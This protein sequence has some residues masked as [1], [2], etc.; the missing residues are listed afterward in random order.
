MN[1]DISQNKT[2]N[3]Q[4]LGVEHKTFVVQKKYW[5]WSE[6]SMFK[7]LFIIFLFVSLSK[8]SNCDILELENSITFTI[9][10]RFV[11]CVA[12]VVG[13]FELKFKILCDFSSGERVVSTFEENDITNKGCNETEKFAILVHGW[14]ESIDIPW[15]QDTISNLTVHRGGCI[16]VIFITS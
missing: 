5:F 9:I 11:S 8:N 2:V 13:N 4:F 15:L 3:S 14:L 1:K 12:Y 10:K 6:K 7:Q 16:M